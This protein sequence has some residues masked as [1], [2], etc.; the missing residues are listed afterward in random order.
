MVAMKQQATLYKL[1]C[2]LWSLRGG[3]EIQN[4]YILL[5]TKG[6]AD[7]AFL[8]RYTIAVGLKFEPEDSVCDLATLGA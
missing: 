7:D 3:S 5:V 6:K 8:G 4:I 2:K 1:C